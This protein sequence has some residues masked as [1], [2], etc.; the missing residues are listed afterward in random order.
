MKNKIIIIDGN[1]LLFRVYH[2]AKVQQSSKKTTFISYFLN[3]LKSY[4][5]MFNPSEII[6]CWDDREP[7]NNINFRRNILESYKATRPDS[8]DLYDHF[9]MIKELMYTLGIKQIWPRI[10]EADDIMYW[11]CDKKYKNKSILVT[12]DTDM[13]QLITDD[14]VDNILYNPQQKTQINKVFLKKKYEI[15]DGNEFIIKKAL[16]GDVSDNIKGV[17]RIRKNR[18]QEIITFLNNSHDLDA[19]RNSHILNEEEY[20]IF[21]R[22]LS[23]MKLSN[24][25]NFP[26]EIEWYEK[27]LSIP[28]ISD[29]EKFKKMIKELDFYNIYKNIDT[30]FNSFSK[31]E[32]SIEQSLSK[33]K[34]FAIDF[35]KD[36]V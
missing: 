33:L 20:D 7:G 3:A 9:S 31:Y 12:T 35:S 32:Q 18:I 16:K 11:L 2:I 28:V 6:I 10:S 5:T 29:K 8:T 34:V 26:E 4:I 25:Y 27:C 21:A 36:L 22:N 1:N 24:I 15:E 23:I 19:L 17:Y 14:L 13:Y 30:W